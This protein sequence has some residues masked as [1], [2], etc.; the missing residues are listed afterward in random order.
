M[1]NLSNRANYDYSDDHIKQIIDALEDVAVHHRV[2]DF[3]QSAEL[4][5][6]HAPIHAFR[7]RTYENVIAQNDR[8][9]QKPVRSRLGRR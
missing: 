4:H 6:P 8:A 5:K 1:G 2:V 3:R 9:D 7:W